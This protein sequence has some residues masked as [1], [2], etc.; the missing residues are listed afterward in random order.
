MGVT[1][2][3]RRQRWDGEV[4]VN[5]CNSNAD[6]GGSK[7]RIATDMEG[8]PCNILKVRTT[9]RFTFSFNPILLLFLCFVITFYF[10][11]DISIALRT[12]T[13]ITTK[14][15]RRTNGKTLLLPS[16]LSL[17]ITNFLPFASFLFLLTLD[18][19]RR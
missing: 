15:E 7:K 17:T 4:G 3:A 1:K 13:T 12:T 11:I 19:L 14:D 16:C 18:R 5:G 6:G 10:S 2:L 8:L 9:T